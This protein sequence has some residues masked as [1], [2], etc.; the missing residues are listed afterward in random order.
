MDFKKF[1]FEKIDA[2]RLPLC[3]MQEIRDKDIDT[4]DAGIHALIGSSSEHS[5]PNDPNYV[6]LPMIREFKATDKNDINHLL[7][8]PN[9]LN[10]TISD[11]ICKLP[12]TVY[13]AFNQKVHRFEHYSNHLMYLKDNNDIPEYYKPMI[14]AYNAFMEAIENPNNK[15]S[16]LT[17]NVSL[18]KKS[19]IKPIEDSSMYY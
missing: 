18:K 12:E 10:Y 8:D 1:N 3:F 9:F 7:C 19:D 14:A 13:D 15:I 11:L 4:S 17:D 5:D 16:D 6:E 2:I